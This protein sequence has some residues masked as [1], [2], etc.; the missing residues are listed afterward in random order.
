[1][2]K[3]CMALPILMILCALSTGAHAETLPFPQD[4][5]L[6]FE[7]VNL[8]SQLEGTNL[9]VNNITLAGGMV[10]FNE[11]VV[12]GIYGGS[13]LIPGTTSGWATPT[14]QGGAIDT[15]TR[16]IGGPQVVRDNVAKY[17]SDPND[18]DENHISSPAKFLTDPLAGTSPGATSYNMVV[19]FAQP[20]V[21]VAFYALDIDAAIGDITAESFRARIYDEN[22]IVQ[23]IVVSGDYSDAAYYVAFGN[24]VGITKLEMQFFRMDGSGNYT[25]TS[26]GG[27]IDYLSFTPVPEPATMFLL[28]FGLIGVGVFVRRKFRK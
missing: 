24:T 15:I 4:I 1:M 21:D 5:K 22:G 2:K 14:S 17:F 10:S 13:R 11:N 3:I 7:G 8:E 19:N 23:E 25:L 20:V 9:G 12:L 16:V 26:G 28:G 27:G 6:G 18:F